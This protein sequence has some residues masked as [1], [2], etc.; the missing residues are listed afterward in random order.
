MGSPQCRGPRRLQP[1]ELPTIKLADFC[2][3]A[4]CQSCQQSVPPSL[5]APASR[6]QVCLDASALPDFS[7]WCG[8]G[9]H[10]PRPSQGPCMGVKLNWPSHIPRSTRSEACIIHLPRPRPPPPTAVPG[11]QVSTTC[12]LTTHNVRTAVWFR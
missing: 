7:W 12:S 11:T 9:K 1:Q 8:R 5:C 10:F 3:T 4:I 2:F 6:A